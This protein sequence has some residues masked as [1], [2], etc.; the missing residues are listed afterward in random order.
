MPIPLSTTHSAGNYPD[1]VRHILNGDPLEQTFLQNPTYDVEFRTD[2]IRDYINNTLEPSIQ[3]L[4]NTT[5]S[6]DQNHDHSGANGEKILN[7]ARVYA[8]SS[9]VD[10]S[11]SLATNGAYTIKA[12]GASF[13]LLKITDGATLDRDKVRFSGSDALH[14]HMESAASDLTLK[15][16]NLALSGKQLVISLDCVIDV[17]GGD[18][19]TITL[20]PS[21]LEGTAGSALGLDGKSSSDGSTNEGVITGDHTDNSED[22][23]QHVVRLLDEATSTNLTNVSSEVIYG[24]LGNT[25]TIATPIW[26]LSFYTVSG[27]HTFL[28]A[29]GNKDVILI[30]TEA[31][32]LTAVPV[33]DTGF[34]ISAKRGY[35]FT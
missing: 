3:S 20:N 23:P 28:Q 19:Q 17:A 5:T 14:D 34:I 27:P 11:F 7:F 16:H 29:D 15:P 24:L 22:L 12:T 6:F 13:N 9:Q 4:T 21:G 31:Y 33:T 1:T 10:A 30:G 25:G 8:N 18:L 35:G 2:V 26:Q 32:S